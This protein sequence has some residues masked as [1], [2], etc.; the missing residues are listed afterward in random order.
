[1]LKNV[2]KQFS[3]KL[4]TNI[5]N[6]NEVYVEMRSDVK[7]LPTDRMRKSVLD[8]IFGDE[9]SLE[10]P[11]VNKLCK[12]V[13]D[14]FGKERALLVP[15]GIMGNILSLTISTT[16]D[17]YIIQGIKSHLNKIESGSQNQMGF[18][19][20]PLMEVDTLPENFDLEEILKS[21]IDI[22]SFANKTSVI[23]FENTHN[24]LGGKI[25]NTELLKNNIIPTIQK[26]KLFKHLR[27]HLD[28]SR[29]LNAAAALQE[30]PKKLVSP[31]HTVNVCLSKGL[32]AP[33]GSL[34]L[35]N[36]SDYEKARVVK[37][38]IGGAMRQAGFIAAPALVALEDWRERFER[39]HENAKFL[40]S[41]LNKI[42]GLKVPIPDTNIVNIYLEQE[43]IKN[44][45]MTE[46]VN[47]LEKN[48]KVLVLNFDDNRY[49]RAV[50][51]HQ[52]SRSQINY[53]IESIQKTIQNF[54]N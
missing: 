19:P 46:I 11:T 9:G 20:F 35:L 32:G 34:V 22:S 14:L 21:K 33:C 25:Q 18:K 36:E 28:G 37:K 26:S 38:N 40:A 54:Y 39:D 30:D 16:R 43:Y 17:C 8:A 27:F 5:R 1:M 24:Y 52:V 49:I 15:S 13:C 6:F 23:A 41:E 2:F 48:Y 3:E 50:I 10:D 42:K 51:H 12:D 7:T 45:K 29:V 44:E 4:N 47:F 53:S 31:F